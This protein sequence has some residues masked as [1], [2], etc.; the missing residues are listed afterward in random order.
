MKDLYHELSQEEHELD[1]KFL[2]SFLKH[3]KKPMIQA[4]WAFRDKL[5]RKLKKKIQEKK[6]AQQQEI[7]KTV[8]NF[9]KWRFRLTGFISAVCAFLFIFILSFFTDFFSHKIFVPSR[10]VEVEGFQSITSGTDTKFD[11]QKP[12]VNSLGTASLTEAETSVGIYRFLYDGKHYPKLESTLPVYQRAGAFVNEVALAKS[13]GSMKFG[14]ISLKKFD[15]ISIKNLQLMGSSTD[16]Y[17]IA[18]DMEKGYL[19]LLD[20]TAAEIEEDFTGPLSEKEISKRIEKKLKGLGISLAAYGKPHF[21][22]TENSPEVWISYPLL[23]NGY[24]VWEP[25]FNHQLTMQAFY[26]MQS[27]QLSLLSVDIAKY[28]YALYP[29]LSQE[30]VLENLAQGGDYFDGGSKSEYAVGIKVEEP[31]T[32]YLV[33]N[34]EE[35]V[36]YVPGLRFAVQSDAVGEVDALYKEL[37]RV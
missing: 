29:T 21:E 9:A 17:E 26:N 5:K 24:P 31:E 7:L 2:H 1:A 6:D 16:L 30:E 33:K 19:S 4:H 36:W 34:V 14:D 13:A 25:V 12:R 20:T 8:P 23:L 10:Y 32:V 27:N 37:V 15:N 11:T 22:F 35:E 3:F 18:V 28:V